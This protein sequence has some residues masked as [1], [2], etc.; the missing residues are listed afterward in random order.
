MIV[1]VALDPKITKRIYI[2]DLEKGKN[3]LSKKT[4]FVSEGGG[5]NIS[6][7]VKAFNE[8]TRLL[9]FLGGRNGE[10]ILNYM[11]R[12]SLDSRFIFIEE[13]NRASTSIVTSDGVLTNID[14]YS[15]R[16]RGSEIE[17]FYSV[18]KEI[19]DRS[20]KVCVSGD[21][22]R[23]LNTSIYSDL[24]LLAREK[25]IYV[26]PPKE[27]LKSVLNSKVYMLVIDLDDLEDMAGLDLL[28]DKDI[29]KIAYNLLLKSADVI[30]IYKGSGNYL[31]LR[32]DIA[33]TMKLNDSYILIEDGCKDAFLG[34]F[35][36]S[37]VRDY[38]FDY[39][40]KV[41]IASHIAS[42]LEYESGLVDM[43]KVKNIMGYIDLEEIDLEDIL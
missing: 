25:D 21:I 9:G 22:P 23:G 10:R 2:E 39:T 40:V 15:P 37:E 17:E 20:K 12:N 24:I 11:K 5:V 18:Y 19:V 8:E 1:T 7:V 14:E 27:S 43:G 29:A 41:A 42:G 28:E 30:A 26:V 38:D 32:K 13:D 16:I 35:I 31:V 4:E 36:A 6:K 33:Y 3:I 34:G